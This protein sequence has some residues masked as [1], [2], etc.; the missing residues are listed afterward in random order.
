MK[1]QVLLS[2]EVTSPGLRVEEGDTRLLLERREGEEEHGDLLEEREL[3]ELEE[4]P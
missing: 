4:G 2:E 1:F 3:V